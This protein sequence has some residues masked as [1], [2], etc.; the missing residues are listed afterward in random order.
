M[1]M[2]ANASGRD[3]HALQCRHTTPHCLGWLIGPS[4]VRKTRLAHRIPFA[5]DNDAYAAFIHGTPWDEAAWKAMLDHV[6]QSAQ[7]P[8]WMLM[9]DVVADRDAT[10]RSWERHHPHASLFGWP[11]AFAVQDGMTAEDV[12]AGADV[13]FIGGTTAWKWRTLEYWCAHF[14]RVH[15][16]RVNTTDRLHLCH[17]SGAESCDGTGWMRRGSGDREERNSWR[18][19]GRFLSGEY[20]APWFSAK[21][22]AHHPPVCPHCSSTSLSI[23][24]CADCGGSL[25]I[26]SI[27]QYVH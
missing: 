26:H 22:T 17:T 4:S 3:F 13:V 21:R 10:L 20:Q 9:P 1:I 11:L 15:V 24:C 5:L 6:W 25:D 14:P 19:L 7:D 16:G 2:P 8:L 27:S 18:D 23:E 12:P